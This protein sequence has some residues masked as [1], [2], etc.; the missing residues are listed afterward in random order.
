MSSEVYVDELRE[1]LPAYNIRTKEIVLLVGKL[2]LDNGVEIWVVDSKE[3]G[4]YVEY[5]SNLIN[6]FYWG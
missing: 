6:P 5:E 1:D 3:K 2:T 4:L